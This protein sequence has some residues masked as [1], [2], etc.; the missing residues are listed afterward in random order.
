MSDIEEFNAGVRLRERALNSIEQR[1][2]SAQ[3]V[4]EVVD[5]SREL[6]GELVACQEL[7]EGHPQ[8]T[9]SVRVLMSRNVS[10]YNAG[11]MRIQELLRS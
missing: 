1:I 10:I 11:G 5:A 9:Q 8:W 3:T 2:R 7:A 4:N 6:A